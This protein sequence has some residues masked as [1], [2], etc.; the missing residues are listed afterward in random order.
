VQQIKEPRFLA[1]RSQLFLHPQIVS[2]IEFIVNSDLPPFP[3]CLECKDKIQQVLFHQN[4][5][6]LHCQACV[7][8]MGQIDVEARAIRMN[9]RA[10]VADKIYGM[11]FGTT[12]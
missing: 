11:P 3:S 9:M 4:H 8:R 2:Q 12:P 6:T 10:A 1:G 7:L 5:V